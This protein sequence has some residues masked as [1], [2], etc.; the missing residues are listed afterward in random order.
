MP[1]GSER[2]TGW[3]S[4]VAEGEGGYGKDEISISSGVPG[5]WRQRSQK[6][7]RVWQGWMSGDAISGMEFRVRCCLSD[8]LATR[9]EAT[10]VHGSRDGL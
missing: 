4:G 5:F 1:V 7:G 3:G 6:G 9:R 2:A 8:T 10:S